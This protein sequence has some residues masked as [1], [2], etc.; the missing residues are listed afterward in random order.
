MHRRIGNAGFAG[1]DH[2]RD[3]GADQ[4]GEDRNENTD[5]RHLDLEGLDLL[6][7]ILRGSADHQAGDEHGDDREQQH[8]VEARADTAED[9]FAKLDQPQ[10][11][12]AAEWRERIVHRIDRAVRGRSRGRRPQRRIDDAE[13]RLLAL[14]VAAGL[15]CADRLVG[16]R[17]RKERVAR[18]LGRHAD[19]E[20]RDE[21]DGHRGEQRP[22]L[23]G[24]ADHPAERVAE[25]RRNEQDRAAFRGS[26]TAASDSRTGAPS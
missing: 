4:R 15:Q 10:R 1:V 26:W 2:H 23:A 12:Q 5:R 20:Q 16:A 6:A 19:R 7:Q 17:L 24:V 22:A 9:H 8:A 25:R 3:A 13:A 21:H 14:H 11:N 18:L